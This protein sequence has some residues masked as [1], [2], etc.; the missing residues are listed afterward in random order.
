MA[1]IALTSI[2]CII[3]LA[4]GT[5]LTCAMF[6][7]WQRERKLDLFFFAKKAQ[8]VH[9]GEVGQEGYDILKGYYISD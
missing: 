9:Q 3:Y 4:L 7:W 2:G 8:Y 5:V 6:C 1:S